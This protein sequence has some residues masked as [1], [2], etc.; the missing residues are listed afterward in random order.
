[1]VRKT[2]EKQ[3]TQLLAEV[4]LDDS[5]V[6]GYY[7]GGNYGDEL[8][9]E[10]LQHTF[11]AQKYTSISFLYQKPLAI[12]LFH[13]DLGYEPIDA[14]KK[15]SVLRTV[16]RRRNLVI[17]GGGLWGLDVNT[18]VV[19]MSCLLFFARWFLGKK[20]YL[21]GVGYYGSTSRR[22]HVAAWLAGKSANQILA[23]DDESY[24]RFRKINTQTYLCDDIAFMLPYIKTDTQGDLKKFEN[25]VSGVTKPTAMISIRR[26]KP[27]QSNSYLK[28]IKTWLSENPHV[29][30]IFILMEPRSVDPEGFATLRSLQRTRTNSAVIDFAYNPTVLYEFFVRRRKTLS[31]IGPQFH[32][33]LV[34]HLAGVRLLPVFYDN[35][36]S[37]LLR[38]LRYGHPIPISKISSADIETFL[39]EGRKV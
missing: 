23:R 18:N 26:F 29:P 24:K 11:Y 12:S 8:L 38:K 32:V 27:N 20:V 39:A 28:A 17:G 33:Q 13:R 34:A 37:Q 21:L 3:I 16:L 4:S 1:M 25:S 9:L 5:F 6:L 2:K 22:G 10:V 36:V 7:G 19:L 14:A 15:L 35:K 30:V 31:Y